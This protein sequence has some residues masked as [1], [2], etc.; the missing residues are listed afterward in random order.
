MDRG[1]RSCTHF[2]SGKVDQTRPSFLSFRRYDRAA[3]KAQIIAQAVLTVQ[4]SQDIVHFK[5]FYGVI[6]VT[7]YN[8]QSRSLFSTFLKAK[9]ETFCFVSFSKSSDVQVMLTFFRWTR[10]SRW[11]ESGQNRHQTEL[12]KRS[13]VSVSKIHSGNITFLLQ[14]DIIKSISETLQICAFK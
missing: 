14:Q 7:R 12:R 10:K 3:S 9:L 4:R 2:F 6:E 11:G 5:V 8:R 13:D 1:A